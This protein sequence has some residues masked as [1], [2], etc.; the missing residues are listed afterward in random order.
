M[1]QLSFPSHVTTQEVVREKS[2]GGA[3]NLCAKAAG[4]EPKQVQE[5][6]KSDRSQFSRWTD[7]K[8]GILWSKLVAL[9][10]KCGND[11]PVLWMLHARGYELSSLRRRESELERELREVKEENAMLRHDKRVLAEA[12]RGSA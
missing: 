11:A 4:L 10:D 1:N 5:A 3:I 6:L 7:D 9:M 12:L 8:E 2:L